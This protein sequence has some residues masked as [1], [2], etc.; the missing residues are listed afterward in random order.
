MEFMDWCPSFIDWTFLCL[1]WGIF[2]LFTLLC[3]Y[4]TSVFIHFSMDM[5]SH[6]F[7]FCSL[8][9]VYFFSKHLFENLLYA[10]HS[11]IS[12]HPKPSRNR[13]SRI[14]SNFSFFSIYTNIHWAKEAL[15]PPLTSSSHCFCLLLHFCCLHKR[16]LSSSWK[17]MW[18]IRIN[19]S[20]VRN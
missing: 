16:Y 13:W 18:A 7:K 4:K 15:H 11:N 10:I 1:L 12:R 8:I 2:S 17:K 6:L 5:I 9:Y 14:L 3:K 20:L 19:Y